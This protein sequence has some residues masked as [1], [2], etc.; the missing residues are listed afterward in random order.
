MSFSLTTFQKVTFFRYFFVFCPRISL[1]SFKIGPSSKKLA[2]YFWNYAFKWVFNLLPFKKLLFP[3]TFCFTQWSVKIDRGLFSSTINTMNTDVVNNNYFSNMTDVIMKFSL[4]SLL[5]FL[6]VPFDNAVIVFCI[7]GSTVH[8]SSQYTL[9]NV[10]FH[11]LKS[12][13][14]LPKSFVF[15]S[16]VGIEEDL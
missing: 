12:Y 6:F 1:N 15:N 2:R 11:Y 14:L 8:S 4:F 7:L 10:F 16:S 13:E 3:G 9:G 5:F